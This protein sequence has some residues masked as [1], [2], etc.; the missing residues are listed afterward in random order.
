MCDWTT[1]NSLKDRWLLEPLII[2]LLIPL[3]FL[4]FK[5]HSQHSPQL[6][7]NL[8]P[9]ANNGL[10]IKWTK[11]PD[12]HISTSTIN[13]LFEIKLLVIYFSVEYILNIVS[14]FKFEMDYQRLPLEGDYRPHYIKVTGSKTIKDAGRGVCIKRTGVVRG[15]SS[16][17]P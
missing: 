8:Q 4:Q 9:K 6:N 17:S 13:C 12:G 10:M 16:P 5:W 14:L 11:L 1:W 2:L 3:L 15:N 7:F